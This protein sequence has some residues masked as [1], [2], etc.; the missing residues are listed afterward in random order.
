M[1]F[2]ERHSRLL[3]SIVLGLMVLLVVYSGIA[4]VAKQ[5]RQPAFESCG[6]GNTYRLN[7]LRAA[8]ASKGISGRKITAAELEKQPAQQAIAEEEVGVEEKRIENLQ[9]IAELTGHPTAEG[10]VTV[11]CAEVD[12]EV[13]P[14]P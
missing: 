13:L 11:E 3:G 5:I 14:F 4:Y 6:R 12:P 7:E 10:A 2:R 1:A 9:G 8:T